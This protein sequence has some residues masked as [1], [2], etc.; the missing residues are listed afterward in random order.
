MHDPYVVWRDAEL[1]GDEL[2]ERGAE[3]LAVRAPADPCFDP[4]GRVHGDLGG[5]PARRDRHAARRESRA[6]VAGAL[7]EGG[8]A[9]AEMAAAPARLALAGAE[10]RQVDMGHRLVE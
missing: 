2:G 1:V 6:A 5:L 7:R 4:A 10:R 9:D 8:K 3:T